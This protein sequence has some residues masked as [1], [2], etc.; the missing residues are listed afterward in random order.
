E[1]EPGAPLPESWALTMIRRSRLIQAA[2]V[3]FR[4]AVMSTSRAV[5]RS[6]APKRESA[7]PRRSF[8]LLWVLLI[9]AAV[10]IGFWHIVVVLIKNT[11]LR[12][13][14]QV[15]G[16]ATLTML[17]VFILIALASLIWVPVG[18]WVGMRPRAAQIVQPIAQFMAAF[19]A[20]LLF[21]IAVFGIVRW[22]LN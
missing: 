22:K 9:I 20:N 10:V 4:A 15:C 3:A 19:P 1:Q 17:R 2:S 13:A 21:P 12:E 18:V 16:L 5:K 11:P 7:R 14:L 6:D 8:D